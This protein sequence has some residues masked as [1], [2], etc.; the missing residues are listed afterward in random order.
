VA[1]VVDA[2]GGRL[3]VD[4]ALAGSIAWTGT[5]GAPS[6]TQPLHLA[7]YP[8]GFGG[9]EYFSGLLDDARIYNRALTAE[10]VQNLYLAGAVV[11]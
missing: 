3:Y 9:A 10:E 5:P 7:R 1:F 4:G 11:P 2:A 8:R 6:T